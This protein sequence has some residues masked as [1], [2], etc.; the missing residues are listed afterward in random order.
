MIP[1]P[2]TR[3]LTSWPLRAMALCC[4][5]VAASAPAQQTLLVHLPSAPVE[6]TGSQAEAITTLAE[7]LSQAL[8]DLR[9]EAKIFRRLDDAMAYLGEHGDEVVLA[10]SDAALVGDFPAASGLEPY[11]RFTR[12]GRPTY[13]RLLVVR[14]DRQELEKLVDLRGR[15]LAVVETAA[16]GAAAFLQRQVFE[17]ELDPAAWFGGIVPVA[18]DFEATAS[19]LYG[20]T[21]AALVAEYNPLLVR[22]LGQEL[23]VVYE[24]PPLSLP[25]LS[26]RSSAF[27]ARLRAALDAALGD[28]AADPQAAPAL[29]GLGIDG[30]DVVSGRSALLAAVSSSPEKAFEIAVPAAGALTLAPPP[31]VAS[32]QLPWTVA[33][34]LPEVELDPAAV[35]AAGDGSRE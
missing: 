4:L 21:D 25:V 8:P 35:G 30:F 9:L 11:R 14:A 28:V 33:V 26:V 3:P 20:Q 12:Q 23:E 7:Y 29:A 5:L 24:T 18:D 31:A 10:L 34:E 32:D 27:D 19:V 17:N 16:G 13:R 15:T 1:R 2:A 6:S 22:N